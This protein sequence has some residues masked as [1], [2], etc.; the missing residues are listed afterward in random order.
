MMP[1]QVGIDLVCRDEVEEA[2][3]V[4]GDRYLQRIYSDEERAQ[5]GRR[6]LALAARFAAKEA[7]IKALRGIDE[8]LTWGSIT[9]APGPD[10]RPTIRLNGAASE[11]AREN[12]LKHLAVSL[13]HRRHLA[14]A[15]VVAELE[16]SM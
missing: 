14:A 13:T 11:L 7:A 5:A 2:L 9:V 12:G 4:H 8:A 15:I 3:A 10:G 6:P 1:F 16:P